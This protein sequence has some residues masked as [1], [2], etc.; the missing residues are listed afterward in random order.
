M[1]SYSKSA[2][3]KKKKNLL[4]NKL[5]WVIT[6]IVVLLLGGGGL[7]YQHNRSEKNKTDNTPVTPRPITDK[8]KNSNPQ[9]STDPS[10]NS[11][12]SKNGTSTTPTNTPSIPMSSLPVTKP[13]G[14]FVSNH[15]PGQ[16]N[17]P[18]EEASVCN[19]TANINC[20]ITFTKDGI[21]K[22][23]PSKT[24]DSAGTAYWPSWT[25]QSIGLT[26]G[27]WTVT[28][29]ATNTQQTESTADTLALQVP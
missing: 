13:S 16:N 25:S 29:V 20:Q 9:T 7:A 21:T 26:T 3:L 6:I 24:A 5:F 18:L 8:T 11:T 22:S 17:S 2:P 19:T 12:N 28:A 27:N 15:K 10:D 4:R 14:S 1:K 23:L